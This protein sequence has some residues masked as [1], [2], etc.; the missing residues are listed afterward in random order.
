MISKNTSL[1]LAGAQGATVQPD[2]GIVFGRLAAGWTV[3]FK[4]RAETPVFIDEKR[5]FTPS[6]QSDRDRYFAFMNTEPGA[7]LLYLVDA[8]GATRSA[9]AVPVVS[10]GATYVDLY[11]LQKISIT[12]HLYDASASRLKAASPAAMTV[13]GQ[14]SASTTTRRDGY[15]EFRDLLVAADHPLFFEASDAAG[16][17]HRYRVDPS[18]RESL[19]LFRFSSKQ[20]TSWVNQ[21]EGGVSPNSGLVVG[22]FPDLIQANPRAKFQPSLHSIVGS[23][24]L[25]PET[26]TLDSQDHLQVKQPVTVASPRFLSVQVPEGA[27]EFQLDDESSRATAWSMLL[28]NS[29]GI[30]FVLGP[31]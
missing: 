7:H 18:H 21:L 17:T 30:V 13:V 29:P 12:G 1:M 11:H 9:I 20:V 16:Y 27:T 19:R 3:Q 2:S 26:Y 15:F 6:Q 4:G 23:S 5:N 24:D 10:G 28:F 14:A 31:D 8:R 25:T 22:A